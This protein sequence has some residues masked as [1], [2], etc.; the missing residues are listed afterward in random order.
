VNIMLEENESVDEE[1]SAERM[2][3]TEVTEKA[4]FS[5]GIRIGSIAKTSYMRKFIATTRQG[6]LN[7]IDINKT[8]ERIDV[9][10]KMIA[11]VGPKNVVVYSRKPY[12]QK[13]VEKFC[14]LTGAIPVLKRFLPGTIT[15]PLLK[16]YVEPEIVL[17]S[18]PFYDKQ[19][20]DEASSICIPVI[21]ICNTDNVVSNVDLVIP[22]NNNGRKALAAVYW[23]LARSVLIALK[24]LQPNEPMKYSIDDFETKPEEES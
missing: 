20:I 17:V 21:A 16:N 4:L 11:R 23:L 1:G 3:T 14:E 22:A 13:P 12:A 9:A 7:I 6:G 18:D 19:A 2:V 5:S 8:L 10:A 24:L 15:N